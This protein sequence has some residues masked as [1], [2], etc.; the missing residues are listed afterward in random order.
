VVQFCETV[1]ETSTLKCFA[2]TPN[3]KN[4][5]HMIA[6][7]LEKGLGE[8]IE[9]GVIMWPETTYNETTWT[10]KQ[11]TEALESKYCWDPLAARSVW[12]FG[13]DQQGPNVFIDDTLPTDISK[14]ELRVV[15]NLIVQGFQWVT[16]EGPL[17]EEP[18]R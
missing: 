18:V 17:I 16:R 3:H 7:P 4:R 9:R 2:D 12:A 13:P 1:V 10:E 6:E 5:L 14:K 8:D 15:K 11:L